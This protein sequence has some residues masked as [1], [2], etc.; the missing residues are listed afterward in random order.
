MNTY[1]QLKD[2]NLLLNNGDNAGIVLLTVD[3]TDSKKLE[4]LIVASDLKSAY[5]LEKKLNRVLAGTGR[6]CH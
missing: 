1:Q 6:H 2:N 5:A 3:D 4:Y